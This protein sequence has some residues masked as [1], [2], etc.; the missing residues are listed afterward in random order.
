MWTLLFWH[1][2]WMIPL[3][4][5][6]VIVFINRSELFYLKLYLFSRFFTINLKCACIQ[7]NS[8]DIIN[9]WEHCEEKMG[10]KKNEKEKKKKWD[11]KIK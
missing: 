5:I 11:D 9:P 4:R 10:E 7:N 3:N 8:W 1:V 2:I 6:I